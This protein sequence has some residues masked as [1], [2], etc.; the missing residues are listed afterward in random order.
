MTKKDT[1]IV[2]QMVSLK[3]RVLPDGGFPASVSGTYRPDATAWAVL[4][5]SFSG[6]GEGIVD[7]AR[8]RLAASQS[9]DGRVPISP[10][11]LGAFW[12]TPIAVMAWHGSEKHKADQQRAVNFLVH[13]TGRHFTNPPD[14]PVAH[15]PSIRGWPWIEETHSMVEPTALSILALRAAGYREHSRTREAIR[16]LMNRQLPNGGWNYGNT[17]V[18]GRELYPQPETTGLA[19][20]ALA[21]EVPNRDLERSIAYLESRVS[22]LRTPLSLGW[23]LIGLHAWGIRPGKT[24]PWV[25]ECLGRQAGSGAFHTADLSLILLAH[26]GWKGTFPFPSNGQRKDS[27]Q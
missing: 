4:A 23:S 18:Y 1:G 10:D 16:M 15:D 6:P 14:S 2:A 8:T 11:H 12:P 25:L 27:V 5:I 22:R 21:G 20:A 3:E 7:K 19:L 26:L 13:T 9:M 24:K 17:M